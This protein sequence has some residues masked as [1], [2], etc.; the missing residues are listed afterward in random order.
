[1]RV[2]VLV[3]AT[4]DSEAGILPTTEMFEAMGKYNEELVKAGIMLAG[5]G[6]HPS[7]KGKRVRFDGQ[8][9]EHARPRAFLHG[10]CH[11]NVRRPNGDVSRHHHLHLCRNGLRAELKPI[12]RLRLRPQL[13]NLLARPEEERLAGADRRAHRFLADAGAVVAHVALHHDLPVL[14]DLRHAERAGHDAVAAGDA[15]RLP[16]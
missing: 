15:P 9:L 13:L 3:K 5:D 1:M 6:L 8:H 2:M 10:R 11:I 12:D 4:A 14:E 7:N 16:R